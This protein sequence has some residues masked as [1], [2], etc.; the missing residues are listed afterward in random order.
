[1]TG[2][3]FPRMLRKLNP[4]ALLAPARSRHIRARERASVVPA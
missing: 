1:M 2:L 3:S 4:D